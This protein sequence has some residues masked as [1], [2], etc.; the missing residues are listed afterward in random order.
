[1]TPKLFPRAL[2]FSVL[3]LPFVA[4]EKKA[5]QGGDAAPIV[6]AVAVDS[7]GETDPIAN[8]AAVA[9]GTYTTWGGASPKSLNYWVDPNSFS[10]GV[11]GL[12]F[13][14]LVT[15]HSTKDEPV[16]VVAQSWETSADG[17]TFTFHLDPRARW[18]DGQ[19]VTAR[20]FQF[21]YDVIMDAKNM[22]SVFRVG[23]SRFARPESPDSLTLVVK[24]KE[25]HW[26]NF[27]EAAG[28]TA[29][30]EHAWKGKN[31]NDLQFDFPVVSG[32][33]AMDEVKR[34][35][36]ISLK[37]RS[38]WWGRA[39][40][41]NLH[42]YNFA[43][44]KYR[45]MEDRNKALEAFKKG[46]DEGGFDAYPVYTAALWAEKTGPADIPAIA[47]GWVAR[48]SVYNR[49]PKGFQGF[50]IN[51]RRPVFQDVRVRTALAHLLNRELMNDKLMYNQYFLLNNYYPDLYP[52]NRNPDAPLINYDPE[53]ARKLLA[54]AGW[55]PG[56]DGVLVKDGRRFSISFLTPATDL[57]HY[58]VYLEDLKK[59]GIEAK[60]E[61]MSASSVGK[62]VDNHDFDLYWAAWGA[63]RLR[64]PEEQWKSSTAD[65]T[66]SYNFPG[67]KDKEVD[68]LIAAQK[69]EDDLGKRNEILKK[70]DKRL[71][72]LAPYIL[73][74]QADNTRLLYW[75]RFG[76]PK[77]VL[78]KF[79]REDAI[80]P[81]WFVDAEKDRKVHAKEKMPVDTGAVRYAD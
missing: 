70:L 50:A 29:F 68:A 33:Y 35:R 27:W 59:A 51:L 32:P 9:G 44:V 47:D 45:F 19:A 54:E 74:W 36:Y 34:E 75:N 78:D 23:L 52:A 26:M 3:A 81:Y 71:T 43:R 41:Y 56:P 57:R 67:L 24:A 55:K 64:N 18:S 77:H 25:K 69:I 48:K 66:A 46:P 12:L 58:N 42:K 28:L 1:M 72:D 62:K 61:Q 17:K 38:D 31:F 60:L 5:A 7:T 65:E 22:T 37:R 13:E 6:D 79:D 20:D 80:I 76:M 10:G 4:C 21:Y 63:G 39:K 11:M 14:P 8:P 73:L 15:L 49:E 30:P 53:K 40:R 16:G 2:L